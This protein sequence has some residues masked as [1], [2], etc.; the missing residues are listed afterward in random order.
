VL[1]PGQS[2]DFQYFFIEPYVVLGRLQSYWRELYKDLGVR[3]LK[4]LPGGAVDCHLGNDHTIAEQHAL[5][6]WDAQLG[7]FVISCLSAQSC[8]AVDGQEVGLSSPPV[9]LRSRALVQVG[10]S[11][12]Y[13]LLPRAEPG[14][15]TSRRPRTP[16]EDVRSWVHA[17]VERR[18]TKRESLSLIAV[19]QQATP[20]A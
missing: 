7:R 15:S 5:I 16:R 4:G 6:S 12:F 18:R 19:E 9:P 3:D 20:E 17:A 11:T 13:F 1:Y 10:A 2:S 8:I 14:R